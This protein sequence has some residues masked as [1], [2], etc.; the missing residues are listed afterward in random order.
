V[1]SD[2]SEPLIGGS[3]GRSDRCAVFHRRGWWHQRIGPGPGA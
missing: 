2:L 1:L 3:A